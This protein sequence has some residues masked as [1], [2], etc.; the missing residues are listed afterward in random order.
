MTKGHD[1]HSQQQQHLMNTV[2]H[3]MINNVYVSHV[4]IFYL[5]IA[6]VIASYIIMLHNY[7]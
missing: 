2:I 1:V 3:C 4:A 6:I 7:A 5:A